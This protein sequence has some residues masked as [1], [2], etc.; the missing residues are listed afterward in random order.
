[1]GPLVTALAAQID[2][3]LDEPYAFFGH[4]MG[5]AVAFEL[6]RRLRR[7]GLPQPRLLIASGARAPQ[8]RRNYTPAPAPDEGRFIEELRRLEGFPK[9]ALEDAAVLRAVLPALEADAGLYRNYVY[10]EDAPLEIPI[11]AYGGADDPNVR[12]E[13]LAAWAEQT[14]ASFAVR[15]FPGGHFYLRSA[16]AEMLAALAADL[17]LAC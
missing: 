2:G 13:H 11:R 6:T 12:P 14:S 9:E 7:A 3:Y 16:Q 17:E 1:M 5:A 4:S 10:A 8:F 15:A